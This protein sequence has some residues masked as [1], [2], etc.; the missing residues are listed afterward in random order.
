MTIT[1]V[2]PMLSLLSCL[3]AGSAF[4]LPALQPQPAW[5]EE[6]SDSDSGDSGSDSASDSD[7]GDSDHGSDSAGESDDSA[8][9]SHDDASGS[10][11]DDRND[12]GSS[13]VSSKDDDSIDHDSMDDGDDYAGK[14]A[15]ER[16]AFLS[17]H[18]GESRTGALPVSKTALRSLDDA[19]SRE[20]M[21]SVSEAEER[22]GLKSGWR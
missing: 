3:L 7:S 1:R 22:E 12:D 8:S 16:A 13:D 2:K 9:E 21:R 17:A 18:P 10:E 15:A 20:G 14:V 4:I 19:V 11:A 6:G 5:S